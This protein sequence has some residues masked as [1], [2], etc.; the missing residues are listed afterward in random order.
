MNPLTKS[1][2]KIMKIAA[3]LL[4]LGT[5]FAIKPYYGGEISIRLNEPEDFAYAPASYSNL[6]FYSLIY[7]N[8]FYLKTNG[9]IVSHIFREY[10][11]DKEVRTLSLQLKDNI[12]FSDGTPITPQNIRVSLKLFL[13][14]NLAASRKL[15]SMIKAFQAQPEENRLVIELLYD[16]PNIVASLTTPELVLTAGSDRAFSGMFFPAEWV[17]NQY[18]ILKPNPFYPGGRSYLDSL[19][20][21]FY[22]YYYPDVFLA[23]PGLLDKKFI[24]L[25]AG[26]YQN[27]YLVFPEGGV[28]DNTRIALHSLLKSFYNDWG[29]ASGEKLLELNALTSNEESPIKLNIPT[30]SGRRVRS[31]LRY[32]K[33]KL[34][35]LSSLRKMEEAFNEFMKK[36]GTPI[37]TIYISDSQLINFMNNTSIKYL[38]IAKTFNRRMPIEEKIKI[39]L[40][41]MSFG[42][43]DE[44]YLKLLN[45][46]D[47]MKFLKNEEMTIDLVSGII[48]KIIN[49][50]FILPICQKRFAIYVK[51]H[52][53]G[54]EMDYYG[55]PLFQKVRIR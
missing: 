45:Q 47:E 52:V 54:I 35:I 16:E 17:K 4:A 39:I 23:D 40:K 9:D 24:E 32:S 41:E 6:I 14:M 1:K 44:N 11:Y 18:I 37:E 19:R 26:V 43:F 46:L 36:W 20:V 27:I 5:I 50:G 15:R 34:Y 51:S 10:N 25:D 13:D 29:Q 33:V 3:V 22:D 30:F 38:L 2:T 31:L 21:V 42:R 48:E 53:K 7:E 28:S 8:F 49:D 12:N 55:K